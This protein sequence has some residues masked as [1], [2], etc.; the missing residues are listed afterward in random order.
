MFDA[1]N[2]KTISTH[3]PLAGRDLHCEPYITVFSIST[4]TPLAGRDFLLCCYWLIIFISTHT[5]LAGRDGLA[6]DVAS[7]YNLFLLT[8]PLRDVTSV[9]N[10]LSEIGSISTHTPLAGRDITGIQD[11]TV[12][13]ISTH[14]PLAGRDINGF[15]PI[16]DAWNF[17]SHA[18]CGT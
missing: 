18:P 17:Y 8:R 10:K 13:V 11:L 7:F 16:M 3:T 6:G 4:H 2:G 9:K 14:T 15:I 5:P 12:T 1:S